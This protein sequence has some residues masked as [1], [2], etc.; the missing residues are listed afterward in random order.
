MRCFDVTRKTEGSNKGSQLV[1]RSCTTGQLALLHTHTHINAR[2]QPLQTSCTNSMKSMCTNT[3]THTHNT[4][5]WPR[6]SHSF[7]STF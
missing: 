4:G 2:T 3:H 1:L 6:L 7:V 5:L